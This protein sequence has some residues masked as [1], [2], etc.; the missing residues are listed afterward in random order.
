MCHNRLTQ[1]ILLSGYIV[2]IFVRKLM[3]GMITV[4]LLTLLKGKALAVR[5]DLTEE[6][7]GDYSM[8]IGEL[9]KKL[10][11]SGFSSLEV[12]HTQKL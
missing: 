12:F 6:Q 3:G 2:L 8:T 11:P 5:V 9:K 1:K 4:K 7:H 10:A